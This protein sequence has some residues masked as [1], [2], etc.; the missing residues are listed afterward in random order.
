MSTISRNREI[1][2]R[3]L[4]KRVAFV[5]KNMAWG[6]SSLIGKLRLN[7]SEVEI[8]FL[9]SRSKIGLTV[10]DLAEKLNVTSGAI[11]QFVD[12]LFEKGLIEREEDQKDRRILRIKFSKLA[13][14]K[15]S[16][17][18]KEYFSLIS[19]IFKNLSDGELRQLSALLGKINSAC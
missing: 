4:L 12:I 2:L 16:E 11:T 10:K 6:R 5:F 13:Q 19:P 9:A 7:R 3:N 14:K 17:F 18:K 15:F 1:L 8:L